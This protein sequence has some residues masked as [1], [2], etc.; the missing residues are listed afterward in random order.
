MYRWS[1]STTTGPIIERY[2]MDVLY[3]KVNPALIAEDFSLQ[4]LVEV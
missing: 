4:P 3:R 2:Y 1:S